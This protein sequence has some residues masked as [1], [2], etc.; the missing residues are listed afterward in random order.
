MLKEQYFGMQVTAYNHDLF[1]LFSLRKCKCLHVSLHFRNQVLDHLPLSPLLL[2]EE[3][4]ANKAYINSTSISL[5]WR[6]REK[7][8]HKKKKK[9]HKKR[10]HQCTQ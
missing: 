2:H 7:L 10:P 9:T 8:L 4:P 3:L 1:F 5:L 6:E